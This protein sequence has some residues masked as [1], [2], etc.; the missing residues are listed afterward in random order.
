[1]DRELLATLVA[2]ASTS[3]SADPGPLARLAARCWPRPADGHVP[4]A[5]DWVRRWGPGPLAAPIAACACATG[6]CGTCN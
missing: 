6:R 1:M 4:A 5:L 3:T 2:S